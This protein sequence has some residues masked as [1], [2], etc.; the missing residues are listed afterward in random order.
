MPVKCIDL[1]DSNRMYD[2][3]YSVFQ[4]CSTTMTT[5]FAIVVSMC[6][7]HM[8]VAME[9]AAGYRQQC[10][11]HCGCHYSMLDCALSFIGCQHKTWSCSGM[12]FIHGMT[13]I[14]L[15]T[16]SSHVSRAWCR[17]PPV[18]YDLGV[19]PTCNSVT[20]LQLQGTFLEPPTRQAG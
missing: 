6:L 20:R 17:S 15:V 5:V 18:E 9:V 14:G 13:A 11:K 10:C 1:Y 8:L 4:H 3:L 12:L 16:L 19:S 2:R 7:Y